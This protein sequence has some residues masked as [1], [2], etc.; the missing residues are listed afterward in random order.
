MYFNCV[1]LISD[2]FCARVEISCC[3]GGV[4]L[5]PNVTLKSLNTE[6]YMTFIV[7]RYILVFF[8]F[9]LKHNN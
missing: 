7:S 6:N 2:N 4:A 5:K 8:M 1:K 3:E 9:Q